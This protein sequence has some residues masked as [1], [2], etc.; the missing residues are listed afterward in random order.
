MQSVHLKNTV[1]EEEKELELIKEA[2]EKGNINALESLPINL[3]RKKKGTTSAKVPKKLS[4]KEIEKREERRKLKEIERI[5]NIQKKLFSERKGK[6]GELKRPNLLEPIKN[7]NNHLNENLVY[8]NKLLK[9][10][11]KVFGPS[12]SIITKTP[13]EKV[14]SVPI[15]IAPQKKMDNSGNINNSNNTQGSTFRKTFTEK[16]EIECEQDKQKDKE[17]LEKLT[18]EEKDFY[19]EQTKD[20]FIFLSEIGLVRFIE[21]FIKEGYDLYEDFL[22]LPKDFF[23]HLDEPFLT[24]SQQKKLYDRINETNNQI[25]LEKIEKAQQEEFKKAVED[26]RGNKTYS[27]FGVNTREGKM[28]GRIGEICYCWNCFKSIPKEKGIVKK[29][30]KDDMDDNIVIDEKIFCSEKCLNEFEAKKKAN[31]ICFE[32][33]K[34][35]DMT[36]GF[37]IVDGQKV[38]SVKCKTKYENSKTT[39]EKIDNQN[40]EEVNENN[41]NKNEEDNGEDEEDDDLNYDP[42]EDF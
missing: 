5:E 30:S 36:K 28:I 9:E 26:F 14:V 11:K 7:R 2:L 6:N 21:N 24:K 4:Q 23:K 16:I 22:Q 38:C 33:K 17:F 15:K 12:E 39:L 31:I 40:K 18:E 42:M 29:Y 32:C 10:C 20:I 1:E 19:Q 37:I 27:N 34:V 35:F 13:K 8:E 3:P 25:E 41:D